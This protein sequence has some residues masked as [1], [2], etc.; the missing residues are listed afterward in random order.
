MEES[1]RAFHKD[2]INIYTTAAKEINYKAKN[3]LDMVNKYGGYEAA[4]RLVMAPGSTYG[5]EV[6]WEK[7]RLDLS[8]EALVLKEKYRSLFSDEIIDLCK[9]RL[10][11]FGYKIDDT[12]ISKK[13]ELYKDKINLENNTKGISEIRL[14]PMSKELEFAN[15]S[16]DTVQQEFFINDL[17]KREECLYFF[18]SSGINC[19]ENT[20]LLFQY[21][22]MI[23][24]SAKLKGI[25]KYKTPYDGVYNG[26]L[27]LE[28]S[29]IKVFQPI[30]LKEIINI[31]HSFKRFSQAKQSFNIECLDDL[32]NLINKK[33][34]VT[35]AEEISEEDSDS[36]IEGAKKQIIINAYERNPKAR[37]KCIDYHGTVCKVCGFD[38]GS[39]YGHELDGKIHVH[40][41]KPLN[42][43][44]EEYEVDPITDLIPIC[45]NCHL[46]VHSK[47][48]AYTPE[49]VKGMMRIQRS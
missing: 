22:N 21:D 20:L 19:N 8:V 32:L 28:R 17:K 18:R 48:P 25:I 45:P 35:I 27:L 30:T 4:K 12:N 11:D 5:F 26:A 41:I 36:L 29:S 14:I 16:I 33:K 23:I 47:N 15:K 46:V 43:I 31:D 39:V 10:K 7:K 13:H 49:E 38:F 42:E 37:Q 34:S 40:H 24:A 3:F 1:K 2:M 6:L 9:K 44:D